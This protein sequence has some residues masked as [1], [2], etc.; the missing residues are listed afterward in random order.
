MRGFCR[1]IR[2]ATTKRPPCKK[3][4]YYVSEEAVIVLIWRLANVFAVEFGELYSIGGAL[5]CDADI[6]SCSHPK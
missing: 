4:V 5:L 6:G 1:S 3:G 2:V